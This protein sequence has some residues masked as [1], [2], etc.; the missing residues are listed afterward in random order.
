MPTIDIV[1]WIIVL[2]LISV[3]AHAAFCIIRGEEYYL[4]GMRFGRG[5]PGNGARFR[6]SFGQ[7]KLMIRRRGSS[8]SEILRPNQE[9]LGKRLFQYEG[10]YPIKLV[11]SKNIPRFDQY[12][13]SKSVTF[14][15]KKQNFDLL[16][17]L[18]LIYLR[19]SNK[20]HGRDL[21]SEPDR[22][23]YNLL[24]KKYKLEDY[25]NNYMAYTPRI[26]VETRKIV[27]GIGKSFGRD[28]PVELLLHDVRNPIRSIIAAVNSDV[29]SRR[30]VG[31]PSTRFVVQY[32]QNQG[33]GL[34]GTFENGSKIGYEKQFTEDK[35]VKATTIPICDEAFGLVGLLC[36]NIDVHKLQSVPRSELA[37]I[38]NQLTEIYTATPDFE[39]EKIS[40][41][42][43]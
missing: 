13:F 14:F 29:V 20:D 25:R 43:H 9:I 21:V 3:L 7:V 2:L 27:E 41:S 28:W 36:L 30:H 4:F 35:K 42:I 11:S 10:L 40:E 32:L 6:P 19:E 31:D 22:E 15:L 34:L 37:Q 38:I 17:I 5:D 1:Q 8:W 26:L 23:N 39:K 33:R 12:I 18:D 16:A 24:V